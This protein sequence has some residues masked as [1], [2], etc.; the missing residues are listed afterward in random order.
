MS[1]FDALILDFDGVVLQSVDVKTRAFT[2]LYAEHG[3]EV[4]AKVVAHHLV[5]GGVSRYEK[6]R[7][8]G[9]EGQSF[10]DDG[11]ANGSGRT[12]RAD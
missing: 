8:M 7:L 4:V 6:F 5:H 10:V 9:R 1:R 11:V 3:P 2:E 12:A